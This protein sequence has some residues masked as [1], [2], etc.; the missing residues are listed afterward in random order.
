MAAY[1]VNNTL[2]GTQQALTTTHK[3]LVL[4]AGATTTRAWVKEFVF[5]TDGTPADQAMTYDI[6]RTTANGTATSVTATPLDL[7]DG[8]YGGVC[9]AN[10][11]VEPTVTALSSVWVSGVNQRATIR[12]VAYPGMELVIPATASAGFAFRAKS[13][14]YTGTGIATVEFST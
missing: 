2:A 8:A 9:V 5:G 11:T 14:G 4:V 7:A 12:W 10:H 1:G 13:P 3:T 6:S